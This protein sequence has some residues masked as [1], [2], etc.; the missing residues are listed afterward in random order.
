LP[1]ESDGLETGEILP[2]VDDSQHSKASLSPLARIGIFAGIIGTAIAGVGF[3]QKLT[4]TPLPTIT[5]EALGEALSFWTGS[6]NAEMAAGHVLILNNTGG[7]PKTILSISGSSRQMKAR[8]MTFWSSDT[9]ASGAV[10]VRQDH[11]YV[12]ILDPVVYPRPHARVRN[13]SLSL[14]YRRTGYPRISVRLHGREVDTAFSGG[15]W[16]AG[17]NL[18]YRIGLNDGQVISVRPGVRT[19]GVRAFAET[20]DRIV[21]TCA[22]GVGLGPWRVG[23]LPWGQ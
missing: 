20:A 14:V 5:S 12:V 17:E 9:C 15:P 4:S 13:H 1:R 2:K 8:P 23:S 22:P 7:A 21:R 6:V 10:A 16:V 3:V 19:R 11:P 18:T